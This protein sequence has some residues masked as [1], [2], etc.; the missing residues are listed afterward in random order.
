MPDEMRADRER[1]AEPGIER[2]RSEREQKDGCCEEKRT[3]SR[4]PPPAQHRADRQHHQDSRYIERAA[5]QHAA[6]Y[7]GLT[8][9]GRREIRAQAKNSEPRRP[10]KKNLS[11]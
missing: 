8:V 3:S 9:K 5:P 11:E 7:F 6:G 10:G 1:R 4:D 2:A